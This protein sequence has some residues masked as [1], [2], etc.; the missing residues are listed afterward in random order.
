MPGEDRASSECAAVARKLI[1]RGDPRGATDRIPNAFAVGHGVAQRIRRRRLRRDERRPSSTCVSSSES[2]RTVRGTAEQ[3]STT[4]VEHEG[5]RRPP[6]HPRRRQRIPRSPLAIRKLGTHSGRSSR[7]LNEPRALCHRE[8]RV[9]D[10]SI[11][12]VFELRIE[13][14]TIG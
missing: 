7:D 10:A 3:T 14:M 11:F 12:E 9:R 5:G 4:V 13:A 2:R 6:L 8:Q 1:T